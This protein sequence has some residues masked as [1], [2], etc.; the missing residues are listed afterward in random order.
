MAFTYTYHIFCL[1]S[2]LGCNTVMF[3]LQYGC[4]INSQFTSLG[5]VVYILTQQQRDKMF[6][7]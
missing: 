5:K 1:F 4:E 3:I 2:I 6:I 7:S